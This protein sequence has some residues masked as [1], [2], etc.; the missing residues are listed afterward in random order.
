MIRWLLAIL[1]AISSAT[2]TAPADRGTVVLPPIPEAMPAAEYTALLAITSTDGRCTVTTVGATVVA[3][4]H[5]LNGAAGWTVD[6]D[7]AWQGPP[8]DWADPAAIPRGAT[9]YGVG[10]PALTGRTPV[11]Y[12]LAVLGTRTVQVG[13]GT[14]LVLM[15]YG[16]STPCSQGASGFVAW[17][18][19][20]DVR[21]P[22]GT[23]SVYSTQTRVTGLPEGQFVCGFA[24]G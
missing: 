8:V 2:A 21:R 20:D 14:V 5:C 24:I 19:I 7:R 9:L 3:A 15:A 6:G 17:V 12:T 13:N 16:D 11:G 1:A 22:V 18:T 23:M 4:A 10:Y